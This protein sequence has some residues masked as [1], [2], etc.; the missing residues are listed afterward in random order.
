[1]TNYRRLRRPGGTYL[2]TVCLEDRGSDLLV[3]RI[4]VLRQA[5]A[6]TMRELPA[7]CPAIVI[8]PGHLH[9]IWTLPEGGA[10]FSERWR[11]IKARFS[12]ALVDH[13]PRSASKIA[14]RERGIWQRRFWSILC[15]AMPSLRRSSPSAGMIR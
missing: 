11:R 7:S 12:L 9:A 8:L 5:Y 13:P 1:M 6:R 10:D 4:D 14:K 2:F 3:A 15:V